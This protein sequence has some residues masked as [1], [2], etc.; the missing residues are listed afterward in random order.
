MDLDDPDNL[1]RLNVRNKR[2][3]EAG[4]QLV[5]VEATAC[6][7]CNTQYVIDL[8]AGKCRCNA[9]GSELSPMFVLEQLMNEES[10]WR[11]TRV[12]YPRRDAKTERT[13]PDEVPPLRQD[14]TDQSLLRSPK[15]RSCERSGTPYELPS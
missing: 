3:D 9:C 10:R 6:R 2:A 14:D 4:P 13:Q 8:K 12:A 1:L 7:H 5:S 11:Q 15:D